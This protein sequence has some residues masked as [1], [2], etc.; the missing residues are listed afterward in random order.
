[1][2]PLWTGRYA[3]DFEG[4]VS[5]FVQ[6]MAYDLLES[7]GTFL[8]GEEAYILADRHT[9]GPGAVRYSPG[10]GSDSHAA[11]EPPFQGTSLYVRRR[12][13]TSN[14]TQTHGTCSARITDG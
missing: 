7:K 5:W 2:V 4:Q 12:N 14:S 9:P 1:M 3:A 10:H 11:S 6:T 8:R 13:T